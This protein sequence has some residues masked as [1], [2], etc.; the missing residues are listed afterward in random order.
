MK[1]ETRGV[2]GDLLNY[3]PSAILPS[4][5]GFLSI[6]VF[7]R[8]FSP[9]EYG[10]YTLVN[11][12]VLFLQMAF[13]SWLNQS[14]LRYYE[15]FRFLS[16]SFFSTGFLSFFALILLISLVWY[17]LLF[18]SRQFYMNTE[19]L[20]FF[21][22]VPPLLTAQAGSRYMLSLI[23]AKRESMRYSIHTSVTSLLKF[24]IPV[25]LFYSLDTGCSGV[26]I[27]IFVA[28]T[29]VL[30]HEGIRFGQIFS[31]KIKNYSG[32]LLKVFIRYGMPLIGLSVASYVL[33]SSDRYMIGIFMGADEVGIYSA[34]YQLA[35]TSISVFSSFLMTAFFPVIV[36]TFENRGREKT[37]YL[38][39]D[40]IGYYLILVL[41][42]VF[43]V[44]LLCKDIASIILGKSFFTAYQVL[45]AVSAGVF[46]LGLSM[47]FNKSFELKE[48]TS[49]IFLITIS[50][51]ILNIV[52]NLILI[53]I[54]GILGA[55][56]STL[57]A[58]MLSFGF[59]VWMGNRMI[60]WYFPWK[61]CLRVV[62]YCVIMCF[63]ITVLPLKDTSG[64]SLILKILAGSLTY[65]ALVAVFEKKRFLTFALPGKV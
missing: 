16:Y 5:F 49:Y 52:L 6:S 26:F 57:I 58:Y 62:F 37:Q 34:G 56:L 60:Q 8:I 11:T 39:S 55:A 20:A 14:A 41:P 10:I 36:Q 63:S 50:A 59:S 53:P 32:D 33:S 9:K 21:L 31:L 51:S 65:L 1:P 19:F 29:L 15:K 27:G 47:Y 38:V 42:V 64:M 18:I 23:R 44:I 12:T 13:F 40:L 24:I 35:E 61:L 28:G 2:L 30:I 17:L 46:F 25:L 48:K 22:W 54:A 45:P 43:G 7:T 3:V 4:L